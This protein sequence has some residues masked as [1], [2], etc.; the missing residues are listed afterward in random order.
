M[1][2][3]TGDIQEAGIAVMLRRWG[4]REG[5]DGGDDRIDVMDLPHHGSADPGAMEWV[6]SVGAGVVLQSTGARRLEGDVWP[7]VLGECERCITSV[8]GACTVRVH[9]D[10]R[11]EVSGFVER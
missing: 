4:R 11:V 10:G 2:L 8:D 6:A 3:L 5:G 1:V 7:A 9:A